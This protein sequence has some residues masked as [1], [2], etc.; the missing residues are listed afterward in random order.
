MA[1][2]ELRSRLNNPVRC[3]WGYS[4]HGNLSVHH[5]WG[6]LVRIGAALA[7]IHSPSHTVL[8]TATWALSHIGTCPFFLVL[9]L[10]PALDTSNRAS[11]S[12][13]GGCSFDR[14]LLLSVKYLISCLYLLAHLGLQNVV[15]LRAPF[16]ASCFFSPSFNTLHS[17]SITSYF[18]VCSAL[19]MIIRGDADWF[20][21]TLY[22]FI[23]SSCS[24][25]TI[26]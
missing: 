26:N 4:G 21:W 13:R 22:M 8:S 19:F 25:L 3:Q 5:E 7:Q 6:R 9:N 2:I 12:S 20:M 16:K 10:N 15:C 24:S 18:H 11:S 14:A 1:V 17:F 23:L